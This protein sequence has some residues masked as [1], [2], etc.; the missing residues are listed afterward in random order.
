MPTL[1]Q[2]SACPVLFCKIYQSNLDSYDVTIS[3][4]EYKPVGY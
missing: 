4:Q 2:F 3:T 1:N